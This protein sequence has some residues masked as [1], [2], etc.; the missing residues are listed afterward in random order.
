MGTKIIQ[1]IKKKVYEGG[2]ILTV[3]I[4]L[5]ISYKAFTIGNK[6]SDFEIRCIYGHEYYVANFW[7]KGFMG[8]HLNDDG[9]PVL[10]EDK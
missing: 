7:G 5:F 3:I 1:F 10:C 8:I 2:F 9:T 6:E 4:A